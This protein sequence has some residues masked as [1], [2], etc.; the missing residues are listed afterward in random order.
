[1]FKASSKLSFDVAEI[2]VI[3]ATGIT[4]SFQKS[5]YKLLCLLNGNSERIPPDVSAQQSG[6]VEDQNAKQ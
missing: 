6:I 5:T 4:T 2:S 1:M 3:L